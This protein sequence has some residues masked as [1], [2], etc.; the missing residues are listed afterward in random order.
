MAVYVTVDIG[1]T[2]ARIATFRT[3]RDSDIVDYHEFDMSGDYMRDMIQLDHEI[4]RI[5]GGIP[6]GVCL[7]IA[8]I[9]NPEKSELTKSP[10][11]EEWTNKPLRHTLE[12]SLQARVVLVNDSTAA[13]LGEAVFHHQ[14]GRDFWYV[15]WGT[16]INF[17]EVLF[18]KN[19]PFIPEREGGHIV[20]DMKAK[21][22]NI[23]GRS[24]RKCGCGRAGCWENLCGGAGIRKRYRKPAE[25]LG[26]NQWKVVCRDFAV[27]LR[28]LVAMNPSIDRI[29]IGGGV[30]VK[31]KGRLA[32]IDR[33]LRH[34]IGMFTAPQLSIVSSGEKAGVV[35]GLAVLKQTSREAS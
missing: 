25:K 20:F 9:L 29:V 5:S 30:M 24:V 16:G 8:G 17:R 15:T 11:L 2:H 34:D 35:G 19:D 31:Q 22:V 6:Q 21:S 26:E 32:I 23:Y 12:S 4:R 18:L 7:A 3:M 13:A 27:G 10:N 28:N 14:L 1:G 33:F